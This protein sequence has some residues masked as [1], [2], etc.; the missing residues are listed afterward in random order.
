[1]GSQE[2]QVLDGWMKASVYVWLFN[3]IAPK[4]LP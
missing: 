4:K 3:K 1:M 2:T